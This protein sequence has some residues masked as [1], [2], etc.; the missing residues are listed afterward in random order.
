LHTAYFEKYLL[1]SKPQPLVLSLDEV[2][3]YFAH[4]DACA[5]YL[6]MLRAWYEKTKTLKVWQQLRLIIVTQP[7]SI[8]T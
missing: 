7:R 2:I 4:P 8:S 5:D 6:S 3:A 1:P